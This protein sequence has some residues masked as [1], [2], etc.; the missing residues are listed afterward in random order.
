M[1][2]GRE[3]TESPLRSRWSTG[4]V[5]TESDELQRFVAGYLAMLPIRKNSTGIDQR[6]NVYVLALTD[7]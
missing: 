7:G 2:S 5:W 4:S 6:F 1:T 3:E